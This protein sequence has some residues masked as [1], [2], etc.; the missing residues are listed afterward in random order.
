M[1]IK[2]VSAFDSRH[3]AWALWRFAQGSFWDTPFVDVCGTRTTTLLA[4]S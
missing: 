4:G 3:F 2:I 1:Y